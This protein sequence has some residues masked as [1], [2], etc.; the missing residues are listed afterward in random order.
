MGVNEAIILAGGLGTRLRPVVADLPKPMA[1]INGRPFLEL[2][3]DYWIS[4]GVSRFVLSIGYLAE[5]ISRHFGSSYGGARVDYAVEEA[6]LGTGG[7]VLLAARRVGGGPFLL[8][9]GDTFFE[10]QLA[11][12][13]SFHQRNRSDVTLSLFRTTDTARYT[14]V[15][16]DSDGRVRAL[17]GEGPGALANGGVY[18]V[19]PEC[20]GNAPVAKC[21]FEADIFPRL[22][23]SGAR[24]FGIEFPGR[25]IDIGVPEDYF[26]APEIIAAQRS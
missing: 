21:S 24:V 6:P 13:A 14:G 18:L 7:A 19:N 9:N 5:T 20:L 1:P 8:L 4:Q 15:Q 17:R 26:R 10:A 16:V 3:M 23:A 25:F 2:Q 12:L 22:L 11:Q